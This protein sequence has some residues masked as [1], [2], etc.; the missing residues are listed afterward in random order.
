MKPVAKAG[1]IAAGY[2]AALAIAW[3]VVQLY[4]AVR[5]NGPDAQGGMFA[6]GE[7]LLFLGVFAV[8]AVPATGAAFFLLRTRPAFWAVF[9]AAA[10]IV[11]LTSLAATLTYYAPR[12][13]E[14]SPIL[15]AWSMF[16]PL[17]ILAAPLFA[18]LFLLA[19]L[20][21]PTR[22]VRVYLFA[23]TAMETVAFVAWLFAL[24]R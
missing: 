17:R 5:G 15:Q 13:F 20:I 23:A 7:S 16:A 12:A 8:A 14:G 2:V 22:R 1:L 9:T 4:D 6:F 3:L 21:A 11:A 10:L 18:P 19:G 24:R